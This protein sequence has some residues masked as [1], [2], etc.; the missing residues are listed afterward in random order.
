MISDKFNNNRF[1]PAKA[2]FFILAGACFIA[3]AGLA[4]MLLWNHI[5]HEVMDVRKVTFWQA[6]G[7][8][9]LAKILFGFRMGPKKSRLGFTKRRYH[10]KQ[11]WAN[12]SEEEKMAFKAKWREKCGR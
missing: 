12:M 7:I 6:L 5:I 10:W 3:V 4:V 2:I 9:A 11:K 1:H 8:F